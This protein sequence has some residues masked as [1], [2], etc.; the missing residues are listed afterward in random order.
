MD[1]TFASPVEAVLV[2]AKCDCTFQLVQRLNA[3][4]RVV[5]NPH[6]LP[7]LTATKRIGPRVW[8]LVTSRYVSLSCAKHLAAKLSMG[9]GVRKVGMNGP[10][11]EVSKE[12][13]P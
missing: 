12:K 5:Y 9:V 8:V 3:A 11:F 4:L 13:K 7:C 6:T 10:V 2:T 1:K